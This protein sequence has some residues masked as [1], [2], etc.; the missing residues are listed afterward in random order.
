MRPVPI[1]AVQRIKDQESFLRFLREDLGWKFQEDLK[2]G[3]LTYEWF[4][5]DFEFKPEA[6][7]GS[8]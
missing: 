3:D 1:E 5:D 8:C 7:R 4:P 6:L 2:F